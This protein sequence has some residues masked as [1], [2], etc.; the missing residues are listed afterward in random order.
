MSY[1]EHKTVISGINVCCDVDTDEGTTQAWCHK[2]VGGIEYTGSLELLAQEGVLEVDCYHTS[3]DRLD[4][5]ILIAP[6]TADRIY[7]WAESKGY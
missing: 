2:I 1:T 6:S 5:V 3:A 7:K 4:D